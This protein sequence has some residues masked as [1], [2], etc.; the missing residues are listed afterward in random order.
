MTMHVLHPPTNWPTDG[1]VSRPHAEQS[2]N[3]ASWRPLLHARMLPHTKRRGAALTKACAILVASRQSEKRREGAK[4]IKRYM[5]SHAV[6]LRKKFFGCA[7]PR[8]TPRSQHDRLLRTADLRRELR[9]DATYGKQS[10]TFL[11][12]F[13]VN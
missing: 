3:G 6:G 11:L 9:A 8:A 5:A 10:L 1:F 4:V 12:H 7:M 13:S 2:S